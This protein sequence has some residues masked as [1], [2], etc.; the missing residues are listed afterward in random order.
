MLHNFTHKNTFYVKKTIID[1]WSRTSTM[2]TGK[3]EKVVKRTPGNLVLP[4]TM[5]NG[6]E[7]IFT[8]VTGEGET[9]VKR[10]I[11]NFVLSI[12]IV[13]LMT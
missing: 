13:N 10:T 3:T 8:M 1:A 12:T 9:V 7:R 2:V 4:I 11:G 5:E 6:I